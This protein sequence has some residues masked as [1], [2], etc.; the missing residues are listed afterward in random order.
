MARLK[1]K[2][3]QKLKLEGRRIENV[4]I[5]NV[6]MMDGTM[7]GKVKCREIHRIDVVK[8]PTDECWVPVFHKE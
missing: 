5:V 2:W 3:Q 1:D 6:S 8:R 7:F 4:D